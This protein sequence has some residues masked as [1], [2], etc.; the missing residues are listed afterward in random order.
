[1]LA[2]QQS[3][4]APGRQ[5]ISIKNKTFKE[6]DVIAFDGSTGKIYA[7]A[8]AT[9]P[10]KISG[11]FATIM[12]WADQNRKLQVRTNADNPKDAKNAF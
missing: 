9:E 5:I 11:E 7:G 2:A 4:F 6:G 8:V 3:K 10:A 12:E 1:M